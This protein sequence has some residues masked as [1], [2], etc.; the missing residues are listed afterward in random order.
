MEPGDIIK[1]LNEI[2]E[3]LTDAKSIKHAKQKINDILKTKVR[4]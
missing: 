2:T 4:C 3:I 1:H